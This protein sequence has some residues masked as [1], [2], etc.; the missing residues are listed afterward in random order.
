M[1]FR[2]L[3]SSFQLQL[4]PLHL[5]LLPAVD[6]AMQHVLWHDYSVANRST[7]GWFGPW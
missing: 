1:N 2:A 3:L 5:G 7:P 4:A 6:A